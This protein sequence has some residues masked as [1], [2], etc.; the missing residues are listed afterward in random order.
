[1]PLYG[2]ITVSV[3]LGIFAIIIPFLLSGFEQQVLV[4]YETN[5]VLAVSAAQRCYRVIFA[6][7][8]QI[9]FLI[10]MSI[11]YYKFKEKIRNNE[12]YFSE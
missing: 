3:V 12:F 1:M 9:V 7:I 10:V 11:M 4:A 5:V 8:V 6:G 2:M